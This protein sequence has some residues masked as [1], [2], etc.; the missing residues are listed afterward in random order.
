MPVLGQFGYAGDYILWWVLYLSVVVHTWC[1]FRFFPRKKH[2]KFGLA[3]G[4]LLIFGCLIGAIALAGESYF[5]FVSVQTDAFG[6]S[7]PARRWFALYT[8]LNSLGCRDKEWA[9]EK[10]AEVRRIAF[11][12]DSVTYGWGIERVED[13]FPDR[14]QNMFEQ[15][16]PGKVE[17]MNVAKPGWGTA[18]QIQPIKDII[19]LYDVNEI[20][21]CHVPNDLE[22]LLPT[23]PEFNPTQPPDPIWFNP[24]SSYLLHQLY[25]WIWLP[26]V[27]TV[28][29]YDD[30]LAKGYNNP[31]IRRMHLQQLEEII[32]FC[33]QR[34]VTLRVVLLPFIHTHDEKL[35]LA[36]IHVRL[37]EFFESKGIDVLDLLPVLAGRDVDTLVVNRYDAHPNE[38]AHGLFAEAIRLAFYGTVIPSNSDKEN[39]SR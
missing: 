9:R 2:R 26:R 25:L 20:V 5:R 27:S 29:E 22:E 14:I 35:P 3:A 28:R 34:R 1:F 39:G 15:H 4:N 16:I 36:D 31:Q 37:R 19:E 8:K 38:E 11:V 33:E 6:M 12:G 23:T 17:I 10:P 30:W 21:L 32:D 7:L 13:R 18:S 24:D